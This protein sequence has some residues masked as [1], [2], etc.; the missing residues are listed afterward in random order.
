VL[1]GRAQRRP[2]NSFAR[3][4]QE[5]AFQQQETDVHDAQDIAA[6]ESDDERIDSEGYTTADDLKMQFICL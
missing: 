1:G 6:N 2:D 5:S 3:Q 4:E